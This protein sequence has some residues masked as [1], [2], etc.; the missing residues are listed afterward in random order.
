VNTNPS[1]P[2]RTGAKDEPTDFFSQFPEFKGSKVPAISD[3]D[4][5][6]VAFAS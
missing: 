4:L 6:D 1:E 3:N 2:H 5:I